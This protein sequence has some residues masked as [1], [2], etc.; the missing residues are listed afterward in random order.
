MG[1]VGALFDL[2]KKKKKRNRLETLFNKGSMNSRPLRWIPHVVRV[3]IGSQDIPSSL[4]LALMASSEEWRREQVRT[5]V[6]LHR[7]ILPKEIRDF[8]KPPGTD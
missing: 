6:V 1:R 4:L 8:P 5:L 2:F 3:V 7:I